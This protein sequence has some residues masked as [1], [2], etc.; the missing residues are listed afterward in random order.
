MSTLSS[1]DITRDVQHH[2]DQISRLYQ[3][4]WGD[5]IHHGYWEADESV[6]DA[7]I[8]LIRKLIELA[9]I[10]PGSRVLDIGCGVGGSSVWLAKNFQCSVLGLTLSPVQ[11]KIATQRAR[12]FKV[13]DATEFRVADANHLDVPSE[14]FDVIWVIECSEHL[15]DKAEFIQ[16]CYDALKPG[17]VM[18]VCA[19]VDESTTLEGKRLVADVCDR[20]I[21]PSLGRLEDYERWMKQSGFKNV[22]A[23]D[24]TAHVAKTWDL[25]I[26]ISERKDVKLLVRALD[27]QT[28]R[29]VESFA[30]MKEAFETDAMGYGM[31]AAFK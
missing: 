8:K 6:T 29:F 28:Q 10:K 18:A 9:K 20:M 2:Y 21:C 31:C 3:M 27:K 26:K 23:K 14:T 1:S 19:W 15:V 5:H 17:G 7:Q 12:R 24:I 22:V 13:S 16:R 25:C 11:A 4:L 30:M